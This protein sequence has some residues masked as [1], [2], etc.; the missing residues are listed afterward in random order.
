MKSTSS[1]LEL[2][3]TEQG[4][5][6]GLV[7]N[8]G[9]AGLQT[10]YH[11]FARLLDAA[12]GERTIKLQAYTLKD[13]SGAYTGHA[14]LRIPPTEDLHGLIVTGMEPS[15]A[16][17]RDEPIWSDMVQLRLWAEDEGI[18]VIWSCLAAHAAVLQSDNIQRRRLPSKLSGLF[19]CALV[20]EVHPLAQG[21]PPVWTL[22]HSRHNGLA[23]SE[24]VENGYTILSHS[25]VAGVDVFA[26]KA[27][28]WG[29]Y[30][31][32]HPEYDA[33]TLLREYLRDLRRFQNGDS[34]HLP[35]VPVNYLDEATQQ[36]L[37]QLWDETSLENTKVSDASRAIL[38]NAHLS[39][40]WSDIAL[41]LISN[42]LD[43]VAEFAAKD[44]A[45]R[46]A[47]ASVDGI[48]APHAAMVLT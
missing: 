39:R 43:I 2:R 5:A 33:D 34:S 25:A 47:Q 9:L 45:T 26:R 17:L 19:E 28:G 20:N 10:T 35:H 41:R 30:F 3:N 40:D 37:S 14:P 21:L 32:G 22:P 6:I 24:L 46:S 8:M 18:P 4:L 36:S 15:T 23:E 42:W 16:D 12:A 48:A 27:G 11:Q 7:N 29:L 13:F 31:Q 38:E 44:R 1:P